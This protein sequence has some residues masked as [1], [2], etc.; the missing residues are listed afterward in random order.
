MKAQLGAFR[1]AHET[2]ALEQITFNLE[3]KDLLTNPTTALLQKD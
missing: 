1:D 2:R 3:L